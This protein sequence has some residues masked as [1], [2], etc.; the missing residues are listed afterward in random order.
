MTRG[1]MEIDALPCGHGVS[2]DIFF[3]TPKSWRAM[4]APCQ[5]RPLV[6]DGFLAMYRH[7]KV[8][9]FLAPEE[10]VEV[11]TGDNHAKIASERAVSCG[12]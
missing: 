2:P 9:R 6:N 1:H 5:L 8:F 7:E 10:A 11:A 3:P 4:F 12:S